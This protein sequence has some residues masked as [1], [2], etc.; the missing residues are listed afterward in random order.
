[1]IAATISIA[2]NDHQNGRF[3]GNAAAFE[4]TAEQ[5]SVS[6]TG[7]EVSVAYGSNLLT[8]AGI[9]YDCFQSW[10]WVGNWCWNDY[11]VALDCARRLLKQLLD[12]GYDVEEFTDGGPFADLVGEVAT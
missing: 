1:M 2:C 10:D 8:I 4:F 3:A 9:G 7:P 6:I 11:E 5:H 12:A